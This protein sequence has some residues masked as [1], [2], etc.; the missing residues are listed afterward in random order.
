MRLT[1]AGK[2]YPCTVKKFEIKSESRNGVVTLWHAKMPL[3][4]YRESHTI[5]ADFAMYPDV[6]RID[7]DCKTKDE[8]EKATI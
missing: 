8:E 6:L 4:P 7:V 1:V 3:V 5:T 2:K